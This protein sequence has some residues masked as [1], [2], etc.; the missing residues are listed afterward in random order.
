[1]PVA[2]GIH[3]AASQLAPVLGIHAHGHTLFELVGSIIGSIGDI[4]LYTAIIGVISLVFLFWVR[5]QLQP[6]LQRLGLGEK[7]AGMIAKAGPVAALVTAILVVWGLGLGDRGVT[8]VG[9]IPSGLP[10]VAIPSFD[11]TLWTALAIPALL[12]AIVGYGSLF[13]RY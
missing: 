13:R 5:S 6:L 2:S 1:L 11:L 8:I 12:I 3:I 4:H 10:E 7:A 9:A